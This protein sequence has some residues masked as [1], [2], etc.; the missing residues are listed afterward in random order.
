VCERVMIRFGSKEELGYEEAFPITCVEV[1]PLAAKFADA[2]THRDF[3]GALMN[4]GIDRSTLGDILIADNVGYL[5]CMESM[6]DF[7]IENLGKVKHTSVL[8][9]RA[10]EM[11]VFADQDKHEMKIQIS[12]E[13]IDGVLAK[14]YKLSR[15]EAIELFRQ[16]RV[17]VNGRLCE[18]NSQMLKSSDVVSARGC[19]KFVYVGQQ[20]IS[21]KGKMN[22]AILYYGK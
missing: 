22:A 20:S 21:K 8:S 16:K 11:P 1:K 18:N 3:L 17:F 15:S 2:L 6:A 13:R 19:G 5:F 4:L 7:I 10:K 14:V 12:S 9:G